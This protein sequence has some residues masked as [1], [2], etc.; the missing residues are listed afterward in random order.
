MPDWKN[1]VRE[2]L[3]SLSLTGT[4]ESDLT[5]EL[6]QHLEDRYRELRSG[7]A[8]DEDAYRQTISELDDMYPLRA[9]FEGSHE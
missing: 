3:T 5:E 6:S 1:L 9:A 4:A 2:R 7:G 8:S